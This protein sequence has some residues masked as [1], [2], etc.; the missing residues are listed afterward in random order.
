M[1]AVDVSIHAPRV[2]RDRW[3]RQRTRATNS[4]QST[5]PVWGATEKLS[6][7]PDDKIVSIHAPRVG[8][9]STA[10]ALSS[11]VVFQ[12]T[13]PVWGATW[14]RYAR[15]PTVAFQS[16]RP[17]WGATCM[18]ARAMER[19]EFQSTRPVW[20]ATEPATDR[21]GLIVVSIHAPRVGRDVL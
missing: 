12:S 5:R 16:T 8:R 21:R 6:E 1:R 11:I 9:D 7:L 19:E 15:M 3:P 10:F 2:G 18:M 14:Y 20:G 4:F 17:V 13:R